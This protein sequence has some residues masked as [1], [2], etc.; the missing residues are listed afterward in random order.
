MGDLF[1]MSNNSNTISNK[2]YSIKKPMSLNIKRR[3]E[4]EKH[5]L[6][7]GYDSNSVAIQKKI[8]RQLNLNIDNKPSLSLASSF[9]MFEVCAE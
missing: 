5:T 2:A 9:F 4:S 6:A 7:I 3:I 8:R 1:V